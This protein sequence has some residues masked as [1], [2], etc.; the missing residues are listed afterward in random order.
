M[1]TDV[2]KEIGHESRFSVRT[3]AKLRAMW[4]PSRWRIPIPGSPRRRSYRMQSYMEATMR[5]RVLRLG[6][7]ALVAFFV[8]I[9]SASADT[10]SYFVQGGVLPDAPSYDWYTD[11]H[12]LRRA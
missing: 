5:S 3:S 6:A 11:V 4:R 10:L 1:V 12:R 2:R 9:S 7:G 8:L